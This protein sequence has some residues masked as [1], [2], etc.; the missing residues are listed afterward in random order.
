M[1]PIRN[2]VNKIYSRLLTITHSLVE[3]HAWL[4]AEFVDRLMSCTLSTFC[5]RDLGVIILNFEGEA[6]GISDESPSSS[7]QFSRSYGDTR[8]DFDRGDK[9]I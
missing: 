5:S 1:L 9:S 4:E 8:Y 2:H 3:P 6:E 7:E